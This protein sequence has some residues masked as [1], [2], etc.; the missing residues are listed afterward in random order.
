MAFSE[1]PTHPAGP[2][3]SARSTSS[4]NPKARSLNLQPLPITSSELHSR[5]WDG[6]D[7]LFITGDAYV[8]H[9]SFGVALLGRVLEK[10]GYRVG[11]IAQPRWDCPDDILRLGRPRLFAGVAAGALDSMLAHYTAF[12]KLRHDDAY[13]PGNVHGARPNRACIVYTGIVRNAFPG[14]PVVL[15]GVEAS[16]RRAS[17]YDFWTDKIRRSIL[18]DSKADLLVYG[19]GEQAVLEIAQRLDACQAYS[20]EQLWGIPGTAFACS[21][22]L[23][24]G[25]Y[26]CFP[27]PRDLVRLPGHE[28]ILADAKMLMTATLALEQQ[29]HQGTCW[30]VQEAGT[31]QVFFAPPAPPLETTELDALYA[32]PFTRRPHPCYTKPIPAA[33]MIQFSITAHRGCAA[34]CTFCAIAQHQGRR[35]Q[36]RSASS[37][38]EEA[39]AFTRHPDWKGSI[40]DVGGPTANMWGARCAA[41]P[42]RC[43]RPDCLFPRRCSHFHID[44]DA[45]VTLLHQ[46][47][48]VEGVRHVRVASGIRYDL[49]GPGDV[50]LRALTREFVGG[51][52]KVAPEHL[53]DSVLRLMRK[54]SRAVFE[55]F[56]RLFDEETQ[57]AGKEQY[58]VPYLISAFPGCTDEDMRELAAWLKQHNWRPRQVQCFIPTPGTVAAAMFHA[59]IDTEGKPIAVAR[60]DRDRLRQHKLLAPP[61]REAT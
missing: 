34:G 27:D 44:E 22:N 38:L 8:D 29:V 17:H 42:S 6:L 50:Y 31:Q 21:V 61:S 1:R 10:A 58:V 25:Q 45:L 48:G 9:P 18:L 35:I 3:G 14:L 28:A 54:P 59:G 19:M 16:M 12:R 11:I 33:D 15:G 32:L 56:L 46:V 49:S 36:S 40:T 60:S 23:D 30:A 51:Q 24:T 5:E 37:V 43:H 13:T 26:A 55:A 41:D 53:C 20:K 7:V 47:A 52:L 4:P 39:R 2:T 57:K